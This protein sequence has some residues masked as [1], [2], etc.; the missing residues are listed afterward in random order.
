VL[1]NYYRTAKKEQKRKEKKWKRKELDTTNVQYC[2]KVT[3][4][5]IVEYRENRDISAIFNAN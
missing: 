1:F 3:Q 4:A 2:A 5:I